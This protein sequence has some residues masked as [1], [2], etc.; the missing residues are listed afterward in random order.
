[1]EIV[2]ASAPQRAET[3]RPRE[4]IERVLSHRF[5]CL[6]ATRVEF[7]GSVRSNCLHS[8]SIGQADASSSVKAERRII[9]G[10]IFVGSSWRCGTTWAVPFLRRGWDDP[11]V[12][13]MPVLAAG[14]GRDLATSE[15][16]HLFLPGF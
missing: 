4:L 9:V 11:G 5:E 1:M 13:Q 3:R 14:A 6:I 10:W 15:A 16:Q 8:E 7:A 2:P 12:E